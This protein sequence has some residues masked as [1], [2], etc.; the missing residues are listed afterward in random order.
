M[1]DLYRSDPLDLIDMIMIR[2]DVIEREA[3][4][5]AAKER[6]PGKMFAIATQAEAIRDAL[7]VLREKCRAVTARPPSQ[8]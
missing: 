7:T 8:P 6:S 2:L 1:E 5:L 3:S 4:E